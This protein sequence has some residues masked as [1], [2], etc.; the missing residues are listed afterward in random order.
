MT[1]RL[2]TI[3][4]G[5]AFLPALARGTLARL[6]TGEALSAATILLPTRRA[7][8]ALQAAFLREAEAPALLLPRLRP[9]AGLSVEDADELALPALMDLPPAVD[10]LRRQAALAGM[11]AK[12]PRHVGG[13]P[14]AE[15]AWALGGELAKLLD[16]IALE[17]AEDIPDD[18]TRLEHRWLQRLDALAPEHLAT[19]WQITTTFL[20]AVVIEWQAWLN[21]AELLDIGVRRVMALRAQRAAWEDAPPAHAVIAAGIGMGGTVPAAMDLLRVIATRLP[22]GHVV[23]SGEDPAS[24]ALAADGLADAPTH[25]FH[26]QRAMLVRMG[27]S[28]ADATPWVEGAAT[29]RAALL[30]TA[31]LPAGALGPWQARD[32]GRWDAALEGVTRLDASDAQDEAT[33]IALALRGALETP[34]ARAALVTPDRDLARRVAAELPRHNILAD[35]SAGQP[36]SDTPPGA[37]LRLVA[38]LAAGE[39][40]PVALLALL[41]HP[42]CAA[43]MAR[44]DLL[45]ATRALE[46]E[47]LRGPAPA[48]GLAGLRA[49][50]LEAATPLLDALEAALSGFVALPAD[51]APRPAGE[52]L[53]THL[54]AAEALAATPEMPG[55]LRLYAQAEGEA[56]ARHL[57]ALPPALA[58][59][60]DLSPADWPGLFEALLASGTTR[61]ARVARGRTGAALHPQVEILGLLEAR[62]LDF[63]LVVLGA[64]DETIW[65]QASDPGPWMSRPM[66]RE[67][68]LPSPE[69]RIGR[70]AADFFLSGLGARRA[71][72]SRAARRGGTPTVPARWLTRLD[73]FLR[74]QGLTMQAA[75]EA[76]WARLLDAPTT[77]RPCGRPAPAPPAGAR[78]HRLTVSDV[79]SLMADPYAFYAARVLNLRPLDPLEQE[80]G[81]ADYGN[82]VH[83]SMH[84]FLAALGPG[85][86]GAEA[87]RTVWEA[88]MAEALRRAAP[89]P[90][91]GAIWTPRLRRIGERVVALEA[92]ARPV[93]TRS[94]A[95][96]KGKLLLARPGGELR[97]DARADRLDLRTDGTLRLV[98]YKTG[99]VPSE[100]DVA[101]GTAPQ[102]PLEALI[103]ARGGF[104]ALPAASVE[105]MEYWR[106]TGGFEVAEV[107]ALKL[108]I[109][110]AVERA[111]ASLEALADRFLFGDAPFL[112]H[113]HPRRR[114]AADYRH[115]SRAAEWSAGEGDGE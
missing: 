20:R 90:A 29:P 28:M 112:A 5:L 9:L 53:Q 68:G 1:M 14:T 78:P 27:A 106:L 25:P 93:L 49:L 19:H 44:A 16:E 110:D 11:A 88:A 81:A 84:R 3:A 87:A 7:A 43:G 79:G 50:G 36:L 82:L 85:W 69:L 64:L 103:A 76:A 30:G 60:A 35:D 57:A 6:G 23:I 61:A 92:Q 86:P 4:P 105:A 108:D 97:L 72:F 47:A 91:I 98:D 80:A 101:S 51:A 45:A 52:L 58:E 66:R 21:A 96:L 70:V 17:E 38:Q 99:T 48:P 102:L 83:A 71:V 32:A 13:P 94:L 40:G 59:L 109:A 107:K 24:A 100:R 62:L 73:T 8:R 65:P 56:L 113:P 63:D 46:R 77:V 114:A 10:A 39:L 89:R 55:G 42:L 15:H 33:A 54:A 22:Q 67:F 34:G 18:P 111:E 2:H 75:P 74:G 115:L 26:G 41:K 12:W 31:L 95:E 104:D 37:F